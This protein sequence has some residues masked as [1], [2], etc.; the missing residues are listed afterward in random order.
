MYCHAP[1]TIYRPD[2]MARRRPRDPG[3]GAPMWQLVP[4][5]KCP[6]CIANRKNDWTG[7]LTAEAMSAAATYFV[8]LTYK[9][10]PTDFVYRDVQLMLKRLRKAA[11]ERN[12]SVRFFC[13]GERG[14]KKGR[15][16]W[17][18]LLFLD[19]PINFAVP[20]PGE[21]WRFWPHGWTQL[22]RLDRADLLRSIR[23]VSKYAV[24][25]MGDGDKSSRSRCS[26]KPLIGSAFLDDYA[27][28]LATSGLPAKGWYNLPG[29]VYTAGRKAGAPLR[30]RLTHAAARRFSRIFMETWD[31][32][33]QGRLY[34]YT[35][36]LVRWSGTMFGFGPA[37]ER[38]DR[39]FCEFRYFP[40]G[41][42]FREQAQARQAK[43][44][45]DH[46]DDGEV[47][48]PEERRAEKRRAYF[49]RQANDAVAA[50]HDFFGDCP[51]VE[52]AAG[53]IYDD[54]QAFLE[55]RTREFQPFWSFRDFGSPQTDYKPV[56]YSEPT[57]A[58][59]G[60]VDPFEG[61]DNIKA[62][63]ERVFEPGAFWLRSLD[64]ER[65]K[66]ADAAAYA[67]RSAGFAAE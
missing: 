27:V 51:E 67:A 8:T 11:A 24:K 6:A 38:F 55:G 50:L 35:S 2:D 17:H 4:C 53:G 20:S 46:D 28:K 30:F 29:V 21:L 9:N 60:E 33:Y 10:E 54:L 23:Y 14:N 61:H 15:I 42:N 1:I 45:S 64:A 3:T 32:K 44:R 36:W 25:S 66:R 43:A 12:F 40:K 49:E 56:V 58:A 26:M 16:H 65:Q 18:L 63:V 22:K 52:S 41:E 59:R 57:G 62:I 5:S 31:E 39:K 47:I 7:R 34:P 19:R 37:P 48:E 13:V